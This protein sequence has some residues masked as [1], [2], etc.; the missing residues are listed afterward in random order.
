MLKVRIFFTQ[1]G[2]ALH[3]SPLAGITNFN[4]SHPS[5]AVAAS[6]AKLGRR[7]TRSAS[8][9]PETCV[10]AALAADACGVG[11]RL[12]RLAWFGRQGA[13]ACVTTCLAAVQGM[14]WMM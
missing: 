9:Q 5:L 10:K 11:S 6:L 13:L 8:G 12:D 4:D 14:P 3:G 1:A 2:L 7:S